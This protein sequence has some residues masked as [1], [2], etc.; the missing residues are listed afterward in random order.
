MLENVKNLID[1]AY[2]NIPLYRRIYKAKPCIESMI[3]FT[4]LPCVNISD[5]AKCNIDDILSEMAEPI[6]VLPPI[7]NRSIFPFPRLESAYDRDRRYEVFHF[8]LEQA[9]IGNGA[10]FLIVT[11]SPHSYFCGEIANCLLFYRHPTWMLIMRQHSFS[12]IQAWVSK[13]KPDCLLFCSDKMIER[14]GELDVPCVFTINQYDW[15]LSEYYG[16]PFRHY[17]I[18]SINEIGWIGVRQSPGAY[19][20]PDEHFY[21]EADPKF[22]SIIVTTIENELQPFIRYRTSDRGKIVSHSLFEISYIGEH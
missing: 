13:F 19:A 9:H 7:D 3:D 6:A 5:Y 22:G 17:D 2:E 12:D 10:S 20:Y 4:G 11:D 14:V 18:Y 15:N 1:Y 8:I 16:L 21:I